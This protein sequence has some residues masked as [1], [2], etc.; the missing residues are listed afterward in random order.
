MKRRVDVLR[1]RAQRKSCFSA[2]RR[3]GGEI[4]DCRIFEVFAGTSNGR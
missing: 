3:R 2:D 4:S 1:C